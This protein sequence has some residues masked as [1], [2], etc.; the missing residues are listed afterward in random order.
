MC[1]L[2]GTKHKVRRLQPVEHVY[3]G[4]V[5]VAVRYEYECSKGHVFPGQSAKAERIYE[6]G[7]K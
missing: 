5:C 1:S 2:D 4:G 6:G 7:G 3:D